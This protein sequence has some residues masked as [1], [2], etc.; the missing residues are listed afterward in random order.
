MIAGLCY[1][2]AIEPSTVDVAL[3][4]EYWINAMQEELL[5]FSRC[6]TK[7]KARLVA[8]GYAQVEGVD[9]DETFTPIARLEAIRLL[10]EIS[11]IQRFKLYQMDVKSAFLND[12]LNEEVYVAQPKGFI[13]FEYPQHVY[14]LNKA[15]YGLKQASKA[16]L[17]GYV[18][19]IRLLGYV[20][21]IRLI[22]KYVHGTS[23]F[24]I[25]YSYETTSICVGYC[26]VDWAASS[27]D[28]KSTLGGCLFL[29]NNLIS[30]FSKKQNSV[31][32]STAKA[33]Y[34]AGSYMM[35]SS[36]DE[37]TTQILSPSIQ[38]MKGRRFKSTPP[39]RPYHLRFEKSQAEVSSKLPKSVPETIDSLY[40]ASFGTHV[41]NVP[42]T[43]LS[44]MDSDDLD[45]FPLAQLLKK[46]TVLDVLVEMPTA[47]SV[48]V[49]TTPEVRTDV[50]SDENELDPPNPDI[51]SEEVPAGTDNN[52]TV[53]PVSPEIPPNISSVPIDGISFHHEENVQRWK[54]LVQRR[55]ADEVNVSDKHQS[56]MSIMNLIERAGL[57][58]TISK[59][60]PFYSQLIREHIVN[61]PDEFNDPSST[62]YQIVH[63]RGFKFVISPT[64]INGFLRNVVDLDCSPLSPS[65]EVLASV[66]S[67]RTLSSWPV[68]GILA[69]ALS[70]KYVIM[71]K[72]GIANWFP[73]F[74]GFSVSAVLGTFLYQICNDNK[75]DTGTFIYNH[76]LRHVDR[77]SSIQV[78]RMSLL[79]ASLLIASWHLGL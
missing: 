70:F 13:N 16:W 14:K 76:L 71:H 23:Y 50:R 6:V 11:C 46:T 29:G 62:D 73:S 18:L 75:M 4:D 33:E 34:I 8:Q 30:W 55:L 10:L 5:Q 7:N 2:S 63:I 51:H 53:L 45:D 37:P 25:L 77:A 9:F 44:D 35:K 17:L 20:L 67:D 59:V 48:D 28:R 27:D 56:C 19:V 69:V 42:E 24:G 43:L 47:P 54:F 31:S 22:L 52:P 21:V 57:F 41:P 78:T 12:Y 68:N 58:K 3:K 64:V 40:P 32:L 26:N 72:I 79:K 36:E 61:L 39:R 49:S 65:T 15:L 1:T 38:K 66:L 60:G 74:H